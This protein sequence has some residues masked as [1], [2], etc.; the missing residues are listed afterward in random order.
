MTDRSVTIRIEF[1]PPKGLDL[2]PRPIGASIHL[3]PEEFRDFFIDGA[4]MALDDSPASWD[5]QEVDRPRLEGLHTWVNDLWGNTNQIIRSLA[6]QK[7]QA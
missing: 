1:N 4:L 3:T 5:L 2:N 6:I 7:E